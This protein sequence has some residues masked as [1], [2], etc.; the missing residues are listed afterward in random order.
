MSEAKDSISY[1]S[2][3]N[4][5]LWGNLSRLN[6]LLIA[7]NISL[8]F[9][10]GLVAQGYYYTFYSIGF[11]IAV[12]IL[13]LIPGPFLSSLWFYVLCLLFEFVGLYFLLASVVYWIRSGNQ[14]SGGL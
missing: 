9:L 2:R 3:Q 8:F 1:F 13:T 11:L 6:N 14:V 7:I 4:P 12:A 5:I 10:S